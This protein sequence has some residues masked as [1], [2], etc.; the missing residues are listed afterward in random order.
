MSPVNC[1]NVV[2]VTFVE[3]TYVKKVRD[4]DIESISKNLLSK[5]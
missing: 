2:L 5:S 1:P 3:M 4:T